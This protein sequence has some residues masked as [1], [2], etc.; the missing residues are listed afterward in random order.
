VAARIG[1]G[2]AGATAVGAEA[3]GLWEAGAGAAAEPP[4]CRSRATPPVLHRTGQ[5]RNRRRREGGGGERATVGEEMR[6]GRRG[7]DEHRPPSW[8]GEE[9]AVGRRWSGG[10]RVGGG[11]E[12]GSVCAAAGE[13]QVGFGDG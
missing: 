3:T 7:G 11:E 5:R 8:P 9:G 4:R 12:R 13:G 6:S 10:D 1:R 2:G